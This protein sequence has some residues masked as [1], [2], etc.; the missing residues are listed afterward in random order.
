MDYEKHLP[1]IVL[2][3]KD[4]QARVRDLIQYFQAKGY[5]HKEAHRIM[6][7]TGSVM[8][9]AAGNEKV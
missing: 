3:N 1:N 2:F 8:R 5:T 6:E 7:L 9:L 4:E